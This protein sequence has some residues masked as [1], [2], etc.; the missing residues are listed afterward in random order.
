MGVPFR[1]APCATCAMLRSAKLH[2]SPA[3]ASDSAR[4][5][6]VISLTCWHCGYECDVAVYI[7]V[8][9]DEDSGDSGDFGDYI[10]LE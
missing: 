4:T 2:V 1:P 8:H 6:Y 9:R 10:P 3:R 7:W 5:P